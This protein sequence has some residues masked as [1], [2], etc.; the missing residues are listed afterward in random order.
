MKDTGFREFFIKLCHDRNF[1]GEFYKNVMSDCNNDEK[2]WIKYYLYNQ[3]DSF[4]KMHMLESNK[5]ATIRFIPIRLDKTLTLE[6]INSIVRKTIEKG[7]AEIN[8]YMDIQG[9]GAIDGNI[10]ISTFMV[11]NRRIGYGCNIKGLIYSSNNPYD[12]YGKVSN[13][14]KSYEI[15]KLITGIELFLKYG[16][17]E[18]LKTYWS[19]MGKTNPDAER[20]FY[21]MDCIDEGITLCNVDLIAFGMNIIRQTLTIIEFKVPED[22]VRRG[23]YYYAKEE[24]EVDRNISCSV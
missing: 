14:I 7:D 2:K 20:L 6:S 10:L 13:V 18:L 11:M 19:S 17:A 4:Y 9:I 24:S 21:G 5:N 1:A 12:F 22:I 3:M 23:I 15:Q 16:K 8:L